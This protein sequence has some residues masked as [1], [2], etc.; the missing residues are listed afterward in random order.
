MCHTE[1]HSFS[2]I[3]DIKIGLD[4]WQVLNKRALNK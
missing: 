4:T 2:G 1:A 3:L